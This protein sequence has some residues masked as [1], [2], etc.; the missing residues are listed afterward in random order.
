MPEFVLIN[1]ARGIDLDG[2]GSVQA[3]HRG[4][5]KVSD[6]VAERI[7]GSSAMHRY[8]AIVEILPGRGSGRATDRLHCRRTLFD[9]EAT[10][11][12]CGTPVPYQE[13]SSLG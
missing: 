11:P 13:G 4:R 8:D 1:G 9:Y 7:R 12:R 6:E 2:G 5:I 10:C 3:D